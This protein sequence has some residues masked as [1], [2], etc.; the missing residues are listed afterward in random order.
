M[1]TRYFKFI[2]ISLII[3]CLLYACKKNDAAEAPAFDI[4]QL[5]QYCL[6]VRV[7]SPE[8]PN[9]TV[10]DFIFDFK[11]GNIAELGSLEGLYTL[12]TKVMEDNSVKISMGLN[13][14]VLFVVEKGKPVIK[15]WK[16][17]GEVTELQLIKK[18]EINLLKGNT[19]TGTY[20]KSN[21]TVLHENFFY[22]YSALNNFSLT[23][24]LKV[25]EPALRGEVYKSL[26]NIAAYVKKVN[27]TTAD[28]E[29][30]ILVDGKLR[31]TYIDRVSNPTQYY[32][33]VFIKK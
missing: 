11:T 24:G 9:S 8:V 14:Y 23:A 21:N 10:S 33:G 18:P 13:D 29:F 5:D 12:T 7:A 16:L 31:V 28:M 17:F 25:N 30:M 32:H 20:Y 3:S 15:Q 26:G 27:S 4:G 22:S 19:F 1:K 6:Y 2:L